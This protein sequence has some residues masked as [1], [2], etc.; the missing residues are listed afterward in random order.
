ML[1]WGRP[2][3]DRVTYCTLVIYAI[4]AGLRWFRWGYPRIRRTGWWQAANCIRASPNAFRKF[5]S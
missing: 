2:D 3:V 1:V 4:N 5:Q